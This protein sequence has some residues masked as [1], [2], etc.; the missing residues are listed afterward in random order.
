MRLD[1]IAAC[2]QAVET[3]AGE[4]ISI[5]RI[6]LDLLAQRADC[7]AREERDAWRASRFRFERDRRR[8]L[9]ARLALR[10]VLGAAL[11]VDLAAVRLAEDG[12]G[13]PCLADDPDR[14]HFNLSHSG[15]LA[16]I[17]L[18]RAAP[19]GV[20]LEL[21]GMMEADGDL[22]AACLCPAE[23]C[24]WNAIGL[25]ARRRAFLDLWTRKEAAL[26]AV[27]LG[28][29]VSPAELDVGFEAQPV[30]LRIGEQ[31]VRVWPVETEGA[32]ASVALV[33]PD[34]DAAQAAPRRECS[35]GASPAKT[36][37]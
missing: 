7:T 23:R 9:A 20:D 28:L 25:A 33:Q 16:L 3:V 10:H 24:Q 1:A 36:I 30:D 12:N 29:S 21:A 6:D 14:C 4:Q 13:K 17:A 11:G 5:H 34:S 2:V 31:S 15:G 8:Y 37:R 18:S 27:G 22:V 19:V 35:T 26:K 32:S